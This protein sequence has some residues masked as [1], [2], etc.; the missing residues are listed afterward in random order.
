MRPTR[1]SHDD[2]LSILEVMI[3]ATILFVVLTGV[4]GLL[5]QST[6]MGA[7]SKQTVVLNNVV[8]SYVEY[9]QA[10]PFKNVELLGVTPD[11]SLTTTTTAVGEFTVVV[12]PQSVEPG[13]ASSLKK[14]T[15]TAT[16]SRGAEQVAQLSTDVIIRDK[17]EFLTEGANPPTVSWGFGMPAVDEV[18]YG[19]YK[20]DGTPLL[21]AANLKALEGKTLRTV[22]I[23]VDGMLL[24][25]N[26]VPPNEAYWEWDSGSQP[27]TWNLTNFLWNT[28]QTRPG[29]TSGTVVPA[30]Q[31]G[32]RTIVI[33]AIDSAGADRAQSYTITVDNH[34]PGAPSVPPVASTVGPALTQYSWGV[35][36]DG[37]DLAY[38][39]QLFVS[40]QDD[41]GNWGAAVTHASA[42]TSADI[43]SA[44]F[45][46]YR[47]EVGAVGPPPKSRVSEERAAMASP[48]ITPPRAVA[49][50]TVVK[51]TTT[52]SLKVS[53]P[54]F[55]VTGTPTYRWESAPSATGPWTFLQDGQSATDTVTG[56]SA[57]PIRYYRCIVSFV[58]TTD[59]DGTAMTITSTVAGP[60]PDAAVV[61]EL[62]EDRWIP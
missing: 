54:K 33:V 40:Q 57:A 59:H 56:V 2:G 46:R 50:S 52:T 16:I 38:G 19:T 26:G 31:D 17:D 21:L 62:L 10:L 29:E 4:L 9:V 28:E 11:G 47:A 61:D 55:P 15:L 35:A 43:A 18:V 20:S 23:T 34:P 39:Y 3:A 30:I 14:L 6:N 1:L 32:R 58:P 27:T 24:Q 5:M 12:V 36:S 25:D 7:Q 22:T 42:T 48:W 41:L 13:G 49:R 37:T 60:T 44:D 45:A 51:K 8:S 53:S